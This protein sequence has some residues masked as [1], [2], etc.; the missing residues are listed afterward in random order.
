MVMVSLLLV[1]GVQ[2]VEP[3]SIAVVDMAKVMNSFPETQEAD[4]SIDEQIEDFEEERK[5]LLETYRTLKEEF[6]ALKKD[7]A[8]PMWSESERTKKAEAAS[9]KL[10]ELRDHEKKIVE[11]T[12]FRKK[13]IEDQRSRLRRR[14]IEKLH[15]IVAD[16]AT[17]KG[18]DLVLDASKGVSMLPAVIYGAEELDITEQIMAITVPEG[19]AEGDKT[20]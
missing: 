17:E 12:D 7:A 13:Q 6:E 18:F 2:A 20:E 8:S 15:K 11:T 10:A 9:D 19:P 14:I 16:F 4:A 3:L 1:G 5:E